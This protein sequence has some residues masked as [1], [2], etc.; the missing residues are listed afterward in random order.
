MPRVVVGSKNP[1]KI[2]AVKV[3]FGKMLG[4]TKVFS[5]KIDSGV[6]K[7][8]IGF[9]QT[10]KGALSRAKQALKSIKGADYGVGLEGGVQDYS[11]GWFTAGVSVIIDKKG[12][13][14]VGISASLPLEKEIINEI[15][16]G[17]ELGEVMEHESG[18]SN[19]KQKQGAFGIRTHGVVTRE[20]AYEHGI[21]AAL[22]RFISRK[23]KS[24]AF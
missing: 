19:V 14:G 16:N 12:K 5:F 22:S 2:M 23:P 10:Y 1:V 8:P 3:V 9:E 11:F 7:Q 15:K 17:K 21:A 24:K 6:G 20:K 13:I 18:I 4:K